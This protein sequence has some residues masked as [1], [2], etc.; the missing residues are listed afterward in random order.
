[1]NG[2]DELP[3]H[4]PDLA[5]PFRWVGFPLGS[6][7]SPLAAGERPWLGIGDVRPCAPFAPGHVGDVSVWSRISVTPPG[8]A[9]APRPSHGAHARLRWDRWYC[10]PRHRRCSYHKMYAEQV[11]IRQSR[12]CKGYPGIWNVHFKASP[13]RPP[14]SGEQLAGGGTPP[15]LVR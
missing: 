12:E 14:L 8:H 11:L 4:L 9:A 1:M 5:R 7:V 13:A 15:P 3:F 6:D 2:D 10:A